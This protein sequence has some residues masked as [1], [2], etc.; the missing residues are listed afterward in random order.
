MLKL[1]LASV[2]P[3]VEGGAV[4]GAVVAVSASAGPAAI[5]AA[6]TSASALGTG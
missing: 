6:S 4:A 5:K 1:L 2:S 3:L